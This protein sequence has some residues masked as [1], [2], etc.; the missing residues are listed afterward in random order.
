MPS[1]DTDK[2]EQNSSKGETKDVR[3]ANEHIREAQESDGA[4]S[5]VDPKKTGNKPRFD[6]DR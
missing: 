3:E 2:K 1:S 5:R 4:D 6:R